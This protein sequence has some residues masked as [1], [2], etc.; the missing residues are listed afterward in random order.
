MRK[1]LAACISAIALVLASGATT[2]AE[3]IAFTARPV[4]APGVSPPPDLEGCNW[5]EKFVQSFLGSA[6]GRAQLVPEDEFAKASRKLNITVIRLYVPKKDGENRR[7]GYRFEFMQDNKPVSVFEI[8]DKTLRNYDSFCGM[9]S[10]LAVNLGLDLSEWLATN[11]LPE[12]GPDCSG[13]HPQEPVALGAHPLFPTSPE[14][15]QDV[16]GCAW[17]REASQN[18]RVEMADKDDDESGLRSF[19]IVPDVLAHKGRRLV[20]RFVKLELRPPLDSQRLPSAELT[21]ELYDG[22]MLIAA[23]RFN[24]SVM[25][26]FTQC[27]TLTR[28]GDAMYPGLRRWLDRDMRFAVPMDWK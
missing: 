16:R 8:E 6:N 25:S 12:C 15:P 22:P 3:T 19:V 28:L 23:N 18:L 1:T 13:L 11:R 10:G 26:A 9:I 4:F 24:A 2:A 7:L 27:G 20:L 5:H 21:A 14:P 17:L